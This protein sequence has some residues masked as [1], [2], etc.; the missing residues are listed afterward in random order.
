[1]RKGISGFFGPDPASLERT[2]ALDLMRAGEKVKSIRSPIAQ[3]SPEDRSDALVPLSLYDPLNRPTLI[4]RVKARLPKRI[5]SIDDGLAGGF[6]AFEF[7]AEIERRLQIRYGE[8]GFVLSNYFDLIGGVGTGTVIATNLALGMP[9]GTAKQMYIEIMTGGMGTKTTLFNRLKYSYEP[10]PVKQVLRRIYGDAD[11]GSAKFKTCLVLVA[12]RLDMGQV[13]Y[14]TNVPSET[15]TDPFRTLEV[16]DLLYGCLSKPTYLPPLEVPLPSGE[17]ALFQDGVVC[18]GSNPTLYLFLLATSPSFALQW[19]TGERWL[20][21]W[22]IGTGHAKAGKLFKGAADVT[23]FSLAP[24]LHELNRLMLQKIANRDPSDGEFE[25][26]PFSRQRYDV[27][28]D[29]DTMLSLGLNDLADVDWTMRTDKEY[30]KAAELFLRVGERARGCV[31]D[32]DF[33]RTFDVRR[34]LKV[35]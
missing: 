27:R 8:A 28:L 29:A 13:A 10:S 12:T 2:L 31:Q 15:R 24:N 26:V 30:Y 16:S 18:V 22:S 9:V 17:K 23:L 4:E 19:R 20:Q 1:L 5:L 21:I 35:D 32:G 34:P 25:R 11:L 14:F 33:L 7:L 3:Q 6:I